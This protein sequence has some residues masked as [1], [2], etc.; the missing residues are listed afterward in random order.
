M[1]KK[2]EKAPHS[3]P[4]TRSKGLEV[5]NPLDH[6]WIELLLESTDPRKK[7]TVRDPTGHLLFYGGERLENF[8]GRGRGRRFHMTLLTPDLKE[9][10]NIYRKEVAI[11]M[12]CFCNATCMEQLKIT[13]A[14]GAKEKLWG[15][16]DQVTKWTPG[17]L[18]DVKNS[19]GKSLLRLRGPKSN[20]TCCGFW[21]P[22]FEIY[23]DNSKVVGVLKQE[24]STAFAHNF[25]LSFP[26]ALNEKLKV[27]LVCICFMVAYRNNDIKPDGY[28]NHLVVGG[29]PT[30]EEDIVIVPGETIV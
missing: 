14:A 7:F 25:N 16:V 17:V 10:V 19:K 9:V 15:T 22:V 6:L 13:A 5:F 23:D 27:M 24:L 21:A 4:T 2:R 28:A 18:L 3:S 11:W 12:G 8:S 30:S 29:T 20:A 26:V 1:G